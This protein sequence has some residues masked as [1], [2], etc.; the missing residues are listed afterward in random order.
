MRDDLTEIVAILDRSGSMN[1]LAT[2]TIG[3]YNNFIKTQSELPGDANLTTVLFDDEY[4][5][6]HDRV[7]IKNV[8]PI[9][10]NE[11]FVRGQTALLDALGKTIKD[12]GTKLNDMNESDRPSKVIVLVI[13]DGYENASH[14]YTNEII[15]EMVERQQNV[16]NWQFLFFGANIDSFNTGVSIGFSGGHTV[17][18][19][20]TIKG[21]ESVYTA[22]TNITKHY[23]GSG[24][25]LDNYKDDIK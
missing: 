21:L 19:S 11:Y 10:N 22:M 17:D 4:E 9:T 3:G 6:L 20:P 23:R 12:I 1:S 16:Y 24:S 25:I 7:D 18:Y 14:K 2:D 13:T 5:L 15:K 8:K